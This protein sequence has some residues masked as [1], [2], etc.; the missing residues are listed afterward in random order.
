MI[1]ESTKKRYEEKIE[2]FRH[3]IDRVNVVMDKKKIKTL[4]DL[5]QVNELF[6]SYSSMYRQVK[7]FQKRGKVTI[8][9]LDRHKLLLNIYNTL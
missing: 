9:M 3:Y 6:T 7:I 8:G 4:M 5:P 1:R 2:V